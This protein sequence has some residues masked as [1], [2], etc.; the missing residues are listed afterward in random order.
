MEGT[1]RRIPLLSKSR[2]MSGLQCHKRLYLECF[3][4]ELADPVT[5]Q[6]Q[7]IF[8]SGT[9]VGEL[10]R[11]LFPGGVL[12][13]EDHMDHAGAIDSTQRELTGAPV[14]PL[15]EA[16]FLHDS[17]RIRADVLVPHT[18]GSFDLVEVKSTT[19]LKEEHISDVG[20][21]LYV[22]L[23][24]DLPVGRA[25]LCHLNREYVYQG[26]DYDLR[27]LFTLEDITYECSV[28]QREFPAL[29][30]D[31]RRSLAER[32]APAI[33]VGRQCT[34]PHT[35][36]FLGHCHANVSEFPVG[37]LPR[38]SGKLLD[39]LKGAGIR[40]IRDIP[41]GFSGLNPLQRRVRDCV[42]MGQPYLNPE[43]PRQLRT[44]RRP[45]HFLD[46]ETFNPPVPLYVGTRPYQQ[47]PFQWSLH[48]LTEDGS[49]RHAEFLHD[50]DGDPRTAFVDSLLAN[51]GV[52]G[53]VLVYSGFEAARLRELAA[54]IPARAEELRAIAEERLVDLLQLVRSHY[55]HPAFHGSFSI[56]AVLPAIAPEMSY[57]DLAISDGTLASMAYAEM[58][59]VGTTPQRKSEI[60]ANLLAYCERDTLAEVAIYRHF[61][62]ARTAS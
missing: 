7:Q 51:L 42:V 1:A 17:V 40:D 43:L 31:M 15:Y 20:I 61:V 3:N 46:F 29:L 58:I 11:D 56:K 19:R 49:L 10:A 21:Q 8:D 47:V 12:I 39:A 16:A 45:L 55:Y 30:Q 36:P 54:A 25:C 26:G 5:E 60:R 44:L 41:A 62:G 13:S 33:E 6:Q 35:C 27:Q 52:R 4:R 34:N 53:P 28:V 24:H 18:D 48:T 57:G 37:Q 9:R 22:L 32:E 38:A 2:F 50:G 14:P 23:G 59:G